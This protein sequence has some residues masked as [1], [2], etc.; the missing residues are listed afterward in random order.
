M[1]LTSTAFAD[2]EPIPARYSC[3]DDNEPPPLQWTGAPPDAA[4]LALVVNDPDAVGGL[5]THWVV[6]GIEPAAQGRITGS[7]PSGA[8][9]TANSAGRAAYLGPC[10]PAGTGTHHYRFTLYALPDRLDVK[11]GAAVNQTTKAIRE[12]ATAHA[13]LV[14]TFAS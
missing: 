6:T 8:Q 14:G 1:R 10:P 9:V 13:R 5:F 7:P 4:E 12:A 3:K 2:G 11:P